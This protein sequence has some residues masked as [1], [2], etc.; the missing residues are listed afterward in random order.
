MSVLEIKKANIVKFVQHHPILKQ[1]PPL[2]ASH[3]IGYGP[4]SSFVTKKVVLLLVRGVGVGSRKLNTPNPQICQ[5][6]Y[7]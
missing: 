3:R 6:E 1:L 4:S 2:F 5:K 7:G